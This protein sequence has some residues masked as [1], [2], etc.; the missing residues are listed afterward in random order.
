MEKDSTVEFKR[1]YRLNFVMVIKTRR[2]SGLRS[3]SL[4]LMGRDGS[5]CMERLEA[6]DIGAIMEQ[7]SGYLR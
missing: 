7:I 1:C 4:T 6:S 3:A 5:D 2:Q